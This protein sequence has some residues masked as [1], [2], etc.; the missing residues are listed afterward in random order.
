[1][2]E[3]RYVFSGPVRCRRA[4]PPLSLTLTGAAAAPHTGVLTLAFAAA[5][6]ADLPEAL[7]DAVV[8]ALGGGR[9]RILA[10]GRDW[11]VSARGLTVTREIAA[12]FYRALPPRPVPARKRLMW[13]AVLTLAASRAGL[14]LLRLLR[15]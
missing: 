9:Y 8:E 5:A 1:M 12:E 13:R 15:R 7:T 10:A 2:T 6:A 11:P 3:P 4:A 14:T